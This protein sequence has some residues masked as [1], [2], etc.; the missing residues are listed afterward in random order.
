MMK[1]LLKTVKD[2]PLVK[3]EGVTNYQVCNLT[4]L[5]AQQEN[6]CESHS[7]YFINGNLPAGQNDVPLKKQ[8]WVRRSDKYPV[9]PGDETV[10]RD[11]EEHTVISDSFTQDFCLDCAYPVDEK[12]HIQWPQTII[13]Y[14]RFES[15]KITP[16]LNFHNSTPVN[17]P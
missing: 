12:G 11:L 14:T 2:K 1:K 4:G 16:N 15:T 10:D 3:P 8:V 9:L 17:V 6:Q 5:L 7:E 13:D